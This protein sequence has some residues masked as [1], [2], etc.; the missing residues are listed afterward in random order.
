MGELL[1]EKEALVARMG[2][3][4]R[5]LMAAVEERDGELEELTRACRETKNKY[6]KIIRETVQNAKENV[7]NSITTHNYKVTT[8]KIRSDF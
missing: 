1:A 6:E 3:R 2:E 5:E 7:M 4:E 8:E